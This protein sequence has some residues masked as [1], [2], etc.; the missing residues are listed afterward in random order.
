MRLFLTENSLQVWTWALF[1]QDIEKTQ[2][3]ELK[4]AVK[5]GVQGIFPFT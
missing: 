5:R 2:I 4:G 3:N 1:L